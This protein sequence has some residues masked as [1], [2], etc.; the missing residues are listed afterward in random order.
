V[1][2][3]RAIEAYL[4]HHCAGQICFNLLKAAAE[5]GDEEEGELI[6]R[7]INQFIKPIEALNRPKLHRR[8]KRVSD[9]ALDLTFDKECA[10]ALVALTHLMQALIDAEKW[11][12]DMDFSEAWNDLGTEVYDRVGNGALLNMV[13]NAG[14]RIAEASLKRLQAEGYYL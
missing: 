6:K 12:P 4:P 7:I 14:L 3:R 8:F 9:I 10:V 1:N 11:E 2:D 5:H 13:G